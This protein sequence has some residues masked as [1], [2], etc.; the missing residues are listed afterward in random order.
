MTR[1]DALSRAG[2]LMRRLLDSRYV[3]HVAQSHYLHHRDASVNQNLIP[4]ADFA[5]GYRTSHVEAVLALRRLE[6]FY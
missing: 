3:Q 5:F 4:G 1:Q 2:W 6:T